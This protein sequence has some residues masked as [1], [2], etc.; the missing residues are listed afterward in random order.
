VPE[1]APAPPAPTDQVAASASGSASPRILILPAEFTV[2]QRGAASLEPVPAWTEDAKRNLAESARRVL[3]ADGR[4][5]LTDTP[6][7]GADHEAEL[8]EHI[9]L[10]KVI[11]SQ[12]DGVVK[13]G[14]KAW[15]ETRNSADYRIGPG[16]QFLKQQ[17]GADYAFLLAGAEVRQTGGSVFMQLLL[18]GAGVYVPGGGTYM[19][20]GIIN[21]DTGRLTW[22][23]SQLGLQAFGMGGTDARNSSGADAAIANILKTYPRTVGLDLGSGMAK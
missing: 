20:A 23:G 15:E 4:F 17:T 11:G 10:F 3:T 12:L 5:T 2:F 16:L 8:R 22:F 14:G 1:S 18:A 21:L 13:M 9:E 6:T 7:V 19:Y